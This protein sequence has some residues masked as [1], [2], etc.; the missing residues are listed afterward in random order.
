[1]PGRPKNTGSEERPSVDCIKAQLA[2]RRTESIATNM[3][4]GIF[5][6]VEIWVESAPISVPIRESTCKFMGSFDSF[7]ELDSG[8]YA[9]VA[10]TSRYRDAELFRR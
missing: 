5:K 10:L 4:A 8:G 7:I 1:M 6:H 3:P 2:G 9:M